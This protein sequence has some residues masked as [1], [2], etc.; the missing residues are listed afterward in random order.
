ML[1]RAVLQENNAYMVFD[2]RARL[3]V[4]FHGCAAGGRGGEEGVVEVGGVEGVLHQTLLSP[5]PFAWQVTGTHLLPL[6]P[7]L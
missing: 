5:L 6:S 3:F 7:H 4:A 1:C 2:V